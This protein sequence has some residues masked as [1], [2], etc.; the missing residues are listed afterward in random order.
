MQ[1]QKYVVLVKIALR[2]VKP[3]CYTGC[4]VQRDAEKFFVSST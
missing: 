2:A 3:L 1:K 4:N